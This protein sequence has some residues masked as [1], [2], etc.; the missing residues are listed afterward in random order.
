MGP[1]GG[2]SNGAW[3]GGVTHT[4]MRTTIL[5][6]FFS[7]CTVV[8]EAQYANWFFGSSGVDFNS[9][10]P[11]LV[12]ANGLPVMT[13]EGTACQSDANGQLLFY[14]NGEVVVDREHEVM[15]NGSGLNGSFSTSQTLIVRDPG[16]STQFYVFT[17]P[18]NVGQ[19]TTLYN[20]LAW[21]RVEMTLNG[22]LGAVTQKNQQLA[23]EVTE[24]LTATFHANGTDIWVLAHG[25]NSDIYLAYLV[26][27][28]GILGPVESHAGRVHALDGLGTIMPALGWMDVRPQGDRLVTVWAELEPPTN[29]G[30]GRIDLLDFDDQTGIVSGGEEISIDEPDRDSRPYGAEFSPDGTKLY[31]SD[32]GNAFGTALHPLW[33]FDL[34]G[35]DV[36]ASRFLVGT[37]SPQ[38]EGECGAVQMAPDGMLYMAVRGSDRSPRVTQPNNAGGACG[39]DPVGLDLATTFTWWGL[40]NCWALNAQRNVLHPSISLSDTTLCGIDSLLLDATWPFTHPFFTPSHFWSTGQQTPVITVS[41]PGEYLVD[42]SFGCDHFMYSSNV[43]Q[44]GVAVDLGEDRRACD[45]D[46]VIL[47]R[48]DRSDVEYLWN[49]VDTAI[50]FHVAQSAQVTLLSI[51]TLG[52]ER[53]DTLRIDLTNCACQVFVPNAFTPNGDGINDV[54]SL[55]HDCDLIELDLTLFDRWGHVVFHTEDPGVSWDG[56]TADKLDVYAFVLHYQWW[57]GQQDERRER[58]GSVTLVR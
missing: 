32:M 44:G 5:T 55:V 45:G 52:C 4:T 6:L 35:A 34:N 20:G 50:S 38:P 49:R 41:Q 14:T 15:P 29:G 53:S 46:E 37:V 51:D 7:A 28:Q 17:I 56:A 24:H 42:I 27:C 1:Y 58:H 13:Q 31:V 23:P 10:P 26:T 21:S 40:P 3:D 19:V 43:A 48:P 39:W 9:T 11:A 22:G 16:D 47:V 54:L 18:A 8:A 2:T 25:W 36:S 33:Q 12:G 57:N 30:I